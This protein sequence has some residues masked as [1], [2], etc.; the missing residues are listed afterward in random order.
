MGVNLEAL[1]CDS[2]ALLSLGGEGVPSTGLTSPGLPEPAAVLSWA[3]IASVF[4]AA[5]QILQ[6]GYVDW[7]VGAS[8]VWRTPLGASVVG[9]TPLGRELPDMAING[10][11][12]CARNTR[13]KIDVGRGLGRELLGIDTGIYLP[14]L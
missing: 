14:P 2:R 13:K 11:F 7:P 6:G 8:V 4:V 3:V 1:Y 5:L 9:W 12:A 10:M